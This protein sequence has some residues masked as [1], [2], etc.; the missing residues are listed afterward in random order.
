[1][2][3][4]WDD[5]SNYNE[6]NNNFNNNHYYYNN[7]NNDDDDDEEEEDEEEEDND[8]GNGN[9][10]EEGNNNNTPPQNAAPPPPPAPQRVKKGKGRQKIKMA[11]IKTDSNLQVTFSKRRAGVFKKASELST[12]CGA[13]STI[14]IFSPGLKPHSFGHPSVEAVANRFLEANRNVDPPPQLSNTD[15]LIMAHGEALRQQRNR[16]L[17][18]VEAE[19][20]RE[21][22]RKNELMISQQQQ[23][24]NFDLE[25]LDLLKQCVLGFKEELDKKLQNAPVLPHPPPYGNNPNDPMMN[26]PG[27]SSFAPMPYAS[28]SN[29]PFGSSSAME[30]YGSSSGA[31]SSRPVNYGYMVQYPA[32]GPGS[33]SGGGNYGDPSAMVPYEAATVIPNEE[34]PDNSGEAAPEE[35]FNDHTQGYAGGNYRGPNHF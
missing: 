11:K 23:F 7:D 32:F 17:I 22:Q 34:D 14:V 10:N 33:S 4:A 29:M 28:S 24:E 26:N 5:G 30:P 12:L 35:D 15:Q 31:S 21:R 18:A 6:D 2:N 8:N 13:E 1:M 20:E 27:G 3:Y 9:D 16:E 25:H 19:L